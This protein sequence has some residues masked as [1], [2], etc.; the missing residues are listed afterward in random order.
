MSVATILGLNTLLALMQMIVAALGQSGMLVPRFVA[1][2]GFLACQTLQPSLAGTAV[3]VAWLILAL[4]GRWRRERGWI[5]AVGLVLGL[6]W[7]GLLG[8]DWLADRFQ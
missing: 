8:L 5:D 3:L 2:V 7:V 4:S 6:V 1:N